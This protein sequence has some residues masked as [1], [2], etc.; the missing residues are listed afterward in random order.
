MLKKI[1]KTTGSLSPS[2]TKDSESTPKINSIDFTASDDGANFDAFK[3]LATLLNLPLWKIK[4][5]C[6]LFQIKNLMAK[7]GK[8]MVRY[9]T[10]E[11]ELE[12]MLYN[13]NQLAVG[14]ILIAPAYIPNTVRYAKKQNHNGPKIHSIIDFP[15]GESLFKSKL[16]DIKESIKLV[17][18][19]TVVIP[20]MLLSPKNLRTLK[21]Q[22]RAIGRFKKIITGIGISA[23]D[24]NEWQIK[25][26]F[27]VVEKSKI[28]H[29]TFLF[30]EVSEAELK[31]KMQVI[32]KY[33]CRK[34]IK[35]LGSVQTIGAVQEL[36]ALSVDEILTPYADQIGADLIKRFNIKTINL[37]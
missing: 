27:R 21:R 6:C 22:V 3:E 24:M 30:G 35:V 28:N 26:L 4:D 18:G 8:V 16:S 5:E 29:V 10:T 13:V 14:T 31:E 17:N 23:M 34:A 11:K 7:I 19:A 2:A 32:N 15:F 9:S 25:T 12:K 36:I 37:K 33:K 20:C 1:S